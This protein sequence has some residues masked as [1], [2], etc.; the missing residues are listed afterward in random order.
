ME[1]AFKILVV[2]VINYTVLML[3]DQGL[4]C[5]LQGIRTDNGI[6]SLGQILNFFRILEI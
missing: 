5:D 6:G 4:K 3:F 1:F 2:K